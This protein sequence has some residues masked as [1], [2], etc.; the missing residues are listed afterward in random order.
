MHVPLCVR[1]AVL[2]LLAPPPPRSPLANCKMTLKNLTCCL[3]KSNF[4]AAHKIEHSTIRFSL[5][6]V[7]M[8]ECCKVFHR[9][10]AAE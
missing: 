7:T 2:L 10:L 3:L 5:V 4:P 8:Y 1:G 9:R 6:P